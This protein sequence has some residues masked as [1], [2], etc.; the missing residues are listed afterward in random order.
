[1]KKRQN[2]GVLVG[3]KVFYYSA[4]AMCSFR[5]VSLE[6]SAVSHQQWHRLDGGIKT[7]KSDLSETAHCSLL[8]NLKMHFKRQRHYFVFSGRSSLCAL[9]AIIVS[10]T[11][12]CVIF[13]SFHMYERDLLLRAWRL[14]S[15]SYAYIVFPLTLT[16]IWNQHS[17][18]DK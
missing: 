13:Y 18:Y 6:S 17:K 12:L 5:L 8:D 14:A 2:S 10:R 4:L 15:L 16:I 3:F 7:G 1:M 11:E 9:R